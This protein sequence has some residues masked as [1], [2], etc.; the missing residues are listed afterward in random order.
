MWLVLTKDS[1]KGFGVVFFTDNTNKRRICR[2][3]HAQSKLQAAAAVAAIC[4]CN[5]QVHT[6]S[7][8]S[9]DISPS[10]TQNLSPK[11]FL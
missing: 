10:S 9:Q 5:P 6:C 11:V 2:K 3:S 4:H 8:H 7:E 1:L